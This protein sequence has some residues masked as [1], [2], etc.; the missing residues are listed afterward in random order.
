[1][2]TALE[3]SGWTLPVAHGERTAVEVTVD[4]RDDVRIDEFRF[5][6]RPADSYETPIWNETV[7]S[8]LEAGLHRVTATWTGT[9]HAGDPVPPGRYHLSAELD[10][11]TTA[12]EPSGT[13]ARQPG[14]TSHEGFGL[15]YFQVED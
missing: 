2:T 15:G 11:T 9:N 8:D 13:C 7:A 4:V 1:M 5:V 3:G 10:A 14:Q 12:A 6:I